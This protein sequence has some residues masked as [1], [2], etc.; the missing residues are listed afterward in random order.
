ML[1][2]FDDSRGTSRYGHRGALTRA[3]HSR[4]LYFEASTA[5]AGEPPTD[6]YVA[7]ITR[8]LEGAAGRF[9]FGFNG[10]DLEARE[11]RIVTA[12][13]AS[14]F[15]PESL[16]AARHYAVDDEGALWLRGMCVE[17]SLRGRRIGPA[18]AAICFADALRHRRSFR[19]VRAAVIV[20]DGVPNE[21]SVRALQKLGFELTN[22]GGEV[23]LEGSHRDRHL[24]AHAISSS[25]R[26]VIIYRKLWLPKSQVP[27]AIQ[28]LSGW[29]G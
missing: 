5:R 26:A 21:N 1:M 6:T 7:F 24:L 10:Q 17:A 29:H 3:S 18:L 23:V 15:V 27:S 13:S 22:E 28:F 16:V 25:G 9:L 20:T 14:S 12:Y 2:S 8:Q 11:A 19:G 4:R